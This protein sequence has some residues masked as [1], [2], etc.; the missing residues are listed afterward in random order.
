[1]NKSTNNGHK[2]LDKNLHSGRSK[3]Y[4]EAFNRQDYFDQYATELNEQRTSKEVDFIESRS[5]LSKNH[6]ILDVACGHGRH[7]NELARR[8]YNVWG[9]DIAPHAIEMAQEN[10]DKLGVHP[11][12]IVGDMKK[13]PYE[14]SEFDRAYNVFT[15]FGYF[16]KTEDDQAM[17]NEISRVLTLGG[18]FLIDVLSLESEHAKFEELGMPDDKAPGWSI[19]PT[20]IQ[21]LSGE[22]RNLTQWFN[23]ETHVLHTLREW[24]EKSKPE[25][26]ESF[27]HL[28]SRT[29]LEKMLRTAHLEPMLVSGNYNGASHSNNNSRTIITAKKQK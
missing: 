6:R 19:I 24:S 14:D 25:M 13:L 8:G 12:F 11:H 17:L 28:Y 23:P 4:I 3:W 1:M 26:H 18:I 5:S 20:K 21:I 10:A 7:A 22:E 15:S 9:V 27:I 16:E 29:E 2:G